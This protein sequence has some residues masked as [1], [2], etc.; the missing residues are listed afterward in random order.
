VDQVNICYKIFH[1]S[2]SS[3]IRDKL[4]EDASRYLI[5][6][7]DALDTP[8]INLMPPG[9]A[10]DFINFDNNFNP[11]FNFK[12]GEVGVWASNYTAWNNFIKTDYD[13]ALLFEDDLLLSEDF[14]E[15]L[16]NL[17]VHLPDDWDFFSVFCHPNQAE[18][19]FKELQVNEFIVH[20]Y[21][22]WSMLCYMV[23]KSGAKKALEFMKS[24]FDQPIDWFVFRNQEVFNVYTLHPSMQNIVA[25]VN[26]PTTIQQVE[27]RVE[28]E[29]GSI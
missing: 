21:Q 23:S 1:I 8:T 26:L 25:L 10:Q 9:Y 27:E 5:T 12:I 3:E 14:Y 2:G 4:F 13:A 24:G 20:A 6:K 16:N 19:Y 28:V 29:N 17:I 22:D 18:R 15:Q 7:Y 11:K